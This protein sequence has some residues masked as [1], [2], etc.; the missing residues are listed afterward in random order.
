MVTAGMHFGWPSQ[1][2]PQLLEESSHI[3]V[4]NSEGSWL[5]VMPCW[6]TIFGGF[7]AAWMVDKYVITL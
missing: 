3:E 7:L 6:T 1:A 4:S 5:A 2:L